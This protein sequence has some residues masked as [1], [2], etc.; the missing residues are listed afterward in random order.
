MKKIIKAM[1]M[2][3]SIRDK[4]AQDTAGK[5]TREILLYFKKKAGK[6]RR[7]HTAVTA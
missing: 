4:Q 3:R 2:V 5:S 6:V 7:A 1:E